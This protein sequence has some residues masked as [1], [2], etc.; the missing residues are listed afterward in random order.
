[1]TLYVFHICDEAGFSKSME[2]RELADDAEAVVIAGAVLVEH[3]SAHHVEIWD[4][5]RP[6]LARHREAPFERL[7]TLTRQPLPA[8][9]RP[10]ARG[11]A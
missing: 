5:D 3:L 9:R 10:A 4:D 2:A 1:M 7:I 6:I 8:L 11:A